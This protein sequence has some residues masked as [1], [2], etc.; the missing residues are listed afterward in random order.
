[1]S[2]PRF[3][4][5]LSLLILLPLALIVPVTA[6][7]TAD[8]PA[9]IVNDE[10]G[11]VRITGLL[12][13]TNGFFT[14]G[15]DEPV[16]ILEDQAGFVDRNRGYTMPV[17]SQVLGELT[18]DFYSSPVSYEITLP[19]Q[20]DA[21]TRDVDFDGQ[22][23]TGVTIYAIAFWQNVW[24]DEFLEKR[25][26]FGG[27]WSNAYA[28]TEADPNPSAKGEI[29]GGK[30]LVYASDDQQSF[31]SAFGDDGKLFTG[32]E[33]TVRLPQGYTVVDLD[34]DPFTFDRSREPEI[35]LI[36]GEGQ[37]QPDFSNQSFTE[38]F[39][40]LIE[41]FRLQYAYTEFKELDWDAL[42][43]QFRPM[44]EEADRSGDFDA[45]ATALRLFIWSIP[46]GH[47]SAP[48]DDAAFERAISGGLGIALRELDDG[49][50]I[51]EFLTEGGPAEQAGI[52]LGAEIL[53]LDGQPLEQAIQNTVPWSAP[54]SAAHVL[55]LQQLRYVVRF[56]LG[57]AVDVT[58]RNPGDT[59]PQTITLETSD[60]IDSFRY[61]SFNR[62]NQPADE[63]VEFS[64]LDNG[65]GYV[66]IIG[67]SENAKQTISLWED[68]IRTLNEQDIPGLIID[69]RHNG[70][71]SGFMADQMAAYFFNE[72]L[73]LGNTATYDAS[74]G[75]FY[76]D[77]SVKQQFILPPDDLRY[78]GPIAV[79][80]GPNCASACEF[81]SWNMLLQDRATTVGM[82][83]TNGIAGGQATYLMP[84]Y[85]LQ[86]STSRS[87]D[88]QGNIIIEGTG[89]APTLP[90]PITEDTIFAPGDIILD[91][92][93]DYLNQ[94]TGG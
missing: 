37:E 88:P 15:V 29:I 48:N 41:L 60:E 67:F 27:G 69:M 33:P 56:P 30:Y 4:F 54:F 45:Y 21:P 43:A 9:T 24:G 18:S 36:E 38:A 78:D 32:D 74:I 86:Y 14:L 3:W 12:I 8:S 65:Y 40:S 46:D 25:D 87:V 91:T 22:T 79:L 49:R 75:D 82:Y 47:L 19:D 89:V 6:Q 94:S 81:F 58:Y 50:I 83:P 53:E 93:V 71:G 2:R 1:M 57:T 26:L 80:V 84:G 72:P 31:P 11:P 28:S 76:S 34:T 92:A 39:D 5:T 52:Q 68:M 10:G 66:R 61:A 13:Y 90:V 35:D 73:E 42:K 85:Q 17:E 23:E 16:I 70:G 62:G 51:V 44:F 77:P 59:D 64:I 20:P 7:Q 55:R 63:P